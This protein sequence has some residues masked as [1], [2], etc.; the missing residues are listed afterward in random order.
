MDGYVF[1][2][3]K[4]LEYGGLAPNLSFVEPARHMPNLCSCYVSTMLHYFQLR[5]P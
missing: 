5:V 4:S 1:K 2:D 3:M